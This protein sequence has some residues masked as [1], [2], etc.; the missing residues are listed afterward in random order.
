MKLLI[1]ESEIKSTIARLG[2][3]IS[4][5]Y[6]DSSLTILGVLTGSVVF[7]ADLIRHI[8]VP[9][10]VDL[11]RASS[12]NGT[13]ATGN[14][15]IPLDAHSPDIYKRDV[16]IVDDIFDTGKTLE[17]ITDYIKDEGASSISSVVL[18]WKEIDRLIDIEPHYF[19]FKI[20]EV[21]V[22][23]YGLDY[24]GKYRNLSHIATLDNSD[25]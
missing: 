8:D 9:L 2:S 13:K 23:G 6:R 11:I 1:K 4:N 15:L 20:P 22:V 24:N 10:H 3:E 25:L 5:D 16:L 18:L 19:G 14:V 17:R 21:F 12:Y 7:L